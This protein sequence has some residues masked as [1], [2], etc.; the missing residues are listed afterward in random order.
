MNATAARSTATTPGFTTVSSEV[1]PARTSPSFSENL[2]R[3]DVVLQDRVEALQAYI[4]A[5]GD[6]VQTKVLKN[7]VA[8][9]RFKNFA[10]VSIQKK[11]EIAIRVKIDPDTIELE[12]GFTQDVRGKGYYGTGDLEILI[13]SDA[14]LERAAPLIL[15][16]YESS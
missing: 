15:Q 1:R 16:S 13:R 6:D 4:E 14:D 5:L 8:F 12:P 11:G 3:S 2:E 7:Y 9:K 10:C